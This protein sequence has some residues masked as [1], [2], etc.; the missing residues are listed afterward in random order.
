YGA[1][2][3]QNLADAFNEEGLSYRNLNLYRQFYLVY[4]QISVYIPH[5]FQ[6]YFGGI[7]QSPIA[8]FQLV[9]KE[10]DDIWQTP[11]AKLSNWVKEEDNS[12]LQSPI[13]E[14]QSVFYW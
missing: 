5:F 2:L 3:L 14:L 7:W 13:A 1:K 4:P 11:S 12:I 9:D 10:E 8:K 6:K